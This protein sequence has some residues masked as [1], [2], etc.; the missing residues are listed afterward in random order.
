MGAMKPFYV[1]QMF[2]F[3]LPVI[4]MIPGAMYM[5]GSHYVCH[6]KEIA[7][8]EEESANEDMQRRIADLK[9]LRAR[10]RKLRDS[11]DGQKQFEETRK[12]RT[13]YNKLLAEL[14]TY[15]IEDVEALSSQIA[16]HHAIGRIR[17][18]DFIR[19]CSRN[20]IH[21]EDLFKEFD[22]DNMGSIAVSD[23]M[24]IVD[25]TLG[26]GAWTEE[27]K[28]CVSELFAGDHDDDPETEDRV[29]LVR[30][31]SFGK[32]LVDRLKVMVVVVCFLVYPTIARKVFQSLSCISNLYDGPSSSYLTKDLS[33]QCDS[34]AHICY[35]LF[36]SLPVLIVFV[37][38]FPVSILILVFRSIHF[39]GWMDEKTMFRYAVFVSGYRKDHWY[40]EAVVCARKVLLS[41][42]A[43]FLGRFGPELQFF[44]GSLLL[45]SC[46]VMQIDAKPFSNKQLNT[47]ETAGLFILF[48]S[49]YNGMFFFW[50]LLD[51][52]SLLILAWITI[53]INIYYTIW[54]VGAVCEDMLHRHPSG[55][56]I[57]GRCYNYHTSLSLVILSGPFLII[58]I[59]LS[60]HD[61]FTCKC[62]KHMHDKKK[63]ELQSHRKTSSLPT[64]LL[65][66]QNLA[67]RDAMQAAMQGRNSEEDNAKRAALERGQ[68]TQGIFSSLIAAAASAAL[69]SNAVAP[70]GVEGSLDDKTPTKVVPM[71]A[72]DDNANS[73]WED[74]EIDENEKN[75]QIRSWD[76]GAG[77]TKQKESDA[78]KRL[79]EKG[80]GNVPTDQETTWL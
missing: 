13:E 70:A 29:E 5:V 10:Q 1:G 23:F 37:I 60:L 73:Q 57:V 38:G 15:G 48:L 58:L 61:L 2:F 63:R 14:H 42:I 27:D 31:L 55:K 20:H 66:K 4:F 69:G 77:E 7:L 78:I 34:T 40:W 39:H 76:G 6:A 16:D 22:P 41:M 71:P 9:N 53:A 51:E 8:E 79:A 17:A 59:G 36:V 75:M 35:I 24:L 64:D 44:F 56:K 45:V 47:I 18:R 3:F 62:I 67:L 33:V 65:R 68:K 72:S 26:E 49:L 25:N 43:V 30:L 19:Y 32:T 74:F 52:D 46:M 11:E 54:V 50:N 12:L 28:L 80:E 21:L